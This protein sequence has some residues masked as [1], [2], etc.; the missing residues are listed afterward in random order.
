MRAPGALGLLAVD[1]LRAGPALRC[2]EDDHRVER[3]VHVVR[4]RRGLDVADLVPHGLEQ[5]GEAT[6]DGHVVLIIEASDELVGLVTH[7]VEELVELFVGDAR[8]D[9]RVG[10][11]VAVEVQD[12]QHDTVGARVHEL[13]GLPAGGQRAG[14]GLTIADDAGNEQA[15]VVHDRA[16]GVGQ[17]VTQLATLVDGARGFRSEVGG[18]AARVGELAEEL[19]QASLILGNVGVRLGVGAVQVGL[20][21]TGRATGPMMN[22]VF[23]PWSAMKRLMWPM[24]KFRPGVVPQCPTRRC[25]T[26]SRVKGSFISG[27]LRR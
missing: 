6:V 3:T 11:L 8:Q 13:V 1:V 2:A 9:G 22:T 20:G 21:G 24:R 19:L 23:W 12:R 25:F 26:S 18:D 10:D 5:L 14:L 17:G 16:I 4:V 27:L 15:R 7:A